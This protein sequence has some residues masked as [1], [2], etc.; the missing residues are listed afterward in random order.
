[1]NIISLLA[2]IGGNLS[3]FLGISLFSFIEF[4]ELLFEIY[5]AKAPAITTG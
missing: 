4:F 2:D 5:Y 3:L 1:M